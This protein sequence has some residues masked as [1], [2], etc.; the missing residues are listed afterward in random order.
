MVAMIEEIIYKRSNARYF[1]LHS[2]NINEQVVFLSSGNVEVQ[3]LECRNNWKLSFKL[4]PN[5]S[6]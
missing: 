1:S 3:A 4:T 2:N 5:K 6:L